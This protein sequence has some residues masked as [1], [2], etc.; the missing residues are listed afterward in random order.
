MWRSENIWCTSDHPGR[1]F[2]VLLSSRLEASG[3]FAGS[4]RGRRNRKASQVLHRLVSENKPVAA[5]LL[6]QKAQK[7]LPGDPP[8]RAD[9]GGH[10][11]RG[12]T[13]GVEGHPMRIAKYRSV[14]RP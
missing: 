3:G 1:P 6:A 8:N 9:G 10:H 14:P 2:E 5:F 13:H 12:A 11:W 7:Y 4:R